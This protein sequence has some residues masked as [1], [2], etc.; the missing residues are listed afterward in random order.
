MR[1][2]QT[3]LTAALLGAGLLTGA[4]ALEEKP[5]R[6]ET[7]QRCQEWS[8]K[9][10]K[11]GRGQERHQVWHVRRV[12]ELDKAPASA[13]LHI[14]ARNIYKTY[15][16][17]TF[18]ADGPARNVHRDMFYHSYEVG[19]LLRPGRNVLVA[20]VYSFNSFP[21]MIAQLELRD[22]TGAL[23]GV[24][25][26]DRSW[27]MFP[28]PWENSEIISACG[29]R[30]E[31]Y[32][33]RRELSGLHDPE[34]TL[35][36]LPAAQEMGSDVDL[37]PAGIPHYRRT[38]LQPKAVVRVAEVKRLFRPKLFGLPLL[39]E[40]PME[41]SQCSVDNAQNLVAGGEPMV[42]ANYPVNVIDRASYYQSWSQGDPLPA[43]RN[44]TVILDFGSIENSFI[45]L[46]VEGN[47]G[48]EVDISWGETLVDG[49]VLPILVV[50]DESEWKLHAKK[51]TLRE[52]RQ[53][54]ESHH[55]QNFRYLQL[56]FRG[57]TRP[58]KVHSVRAIKSEQPLARRGWFRCSDPFITQ[59]FDVNVATLRNVTYDTFMDNTFRE[60]NVWG[61]E[62]TEGCYSSC[63]A[64]FGDVPVL[65]KQVDLWTKSAMA[66]PFKGAIPRA[67]GG[68]PQRPDGIINHPTRTMTWIAK[69]GLWCEDTDDYQRKV[70][71]F[72]E[73]FLDW[74]KRRS[75]Q[76]G[77]QSMVG[78]VAGEGPRIDW[79]DHSGGRDPSE[80]SIAVNLLQSI[81]LE[82]AAQ[83]FAAYGEAGKAREYAARSEHIRTFVY[84]NLWDE[85]RGLYRDGINEELSN[86]SR[87]CSE[88]GNSLAL[89]CGLGRNGRK[90]K[91]LATLSRIEQHGDIPQ[92]GPSFMIHTL[93]SLFAV[94]EGCA[95]LDLMRDRYPRM[96]ANGVDK[97]WE[98][99]S[100]ASAGTKWGPGYRCLSQAAHGSPAWFQLTEIL[101]VRPTKPG[102]AE[103]T[104]EP[105]P[106]D[107][108]WA[109]GVVPSPAGDI[110]VRWEK[111]GKTLTLTLTVPEGT[112]AKVKLPGAGEAKILPPGKHEVKDWGKATIEKERR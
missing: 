62:I 1:S 50:K 74:R 26:T 93:A 67:L 90:E 76:H 4:W 20:E 52:G 28:A 56:T 44:A 46:D 110:P 54:W 87:S 58:L 9:W 23:N 36:S 73:N 83:T 30:T 14:S 16:N 68:S 95:A 81:L 33:A 75:N 41:V 96:F 65:Q 34:A 24:I 7:G 103:F 102:F 59:L 15:I 31:L 27:T 25:G 53:R 88:Q 18:V 99:W 86:L 12:V 64:S 101:G 109:E 39:A 47:A 91:I 48:A 19:K 13:V 89:Y 60:R 111:R 21:S 2:I 29:T 38:V 80:I 106:C 78:A 92:S 72:L 107:L 97:F 108:T 57:L 32:D 43:V 105:K 63:L 8:A 84:E 22:D 6:F 98:E 40:I 37:E 49:R 17:G 71:P 100:W 79:L 104:V 82:E 94:G 45:D 77:L 35:D 5:V 112:L 55:W 11:E 10:I 61:G 85:A 66:G 69:Y 42:I 70:L 3:T 51:Y